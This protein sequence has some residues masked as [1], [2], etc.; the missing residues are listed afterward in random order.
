MPLPE[1]EGIVR[2]ERAGTDP[3][4]VIRAPVAM[5]G[6]RQGSRALRLDAQLHKPTDFPGPRDHPYLPIAPGRCSAAR[7]DSPRIRGDY[8]HKLA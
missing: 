5:W 4:Q 1:A 8:F 2:L 6:R 3:A 7:V